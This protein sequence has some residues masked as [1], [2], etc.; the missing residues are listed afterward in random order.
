MTINAWTPTTI[1]YR[2]TST[3]G[4]VAVSLREA[5][6]GWTLHVGDPIGEL[7]HVATFGPRA[8]FG[9]VEG[10]LSTFTPRPSE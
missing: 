10:F 4:A 2:T 6:K 7:E 1:G 5:G 8:G 9:V 3:D